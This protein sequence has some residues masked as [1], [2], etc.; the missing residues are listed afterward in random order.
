MS[1]NDNQTQKPSIKLD[2]GMTVEEVKTLLTASMGDKERGFFRAIYDTTFRAQELL[3]CNIEDYNKGTG[4]LTCLKPKSKYSSRLD[5]TIQ[6]PPKH[7]LISKS[8]QLLFKRIIGNRKKGPIFVNRKGQRCSITYF[9]MYI[10]D[11][12]TRIGIQKIT[13]ITKTGKKYHL[14]TIQGLRESGE[15]H[16]DLRG[17]DKDITARGAQH[18]ST[19]K[20]KYYKKSGWEE[21]Q[22]QQKKYHPSFQED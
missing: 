14:V 11:L 2:R 5:K 17:A 6:P 16:M 8:T 20:E 12:A 19:V 21:Y 7:S 13:H 18:S 22:E 3:K 15:R 9:Q 1:N 10:N 4:E